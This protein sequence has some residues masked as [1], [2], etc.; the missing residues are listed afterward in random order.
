MNQKPEQCITGVLRTCNIK[1][2]FLSTL[3]SVCWNISKSPVDYFVYLVA[4]DLVA[5]L[6]FK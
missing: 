4:L 5:L 3:E 2:A 6:S 1:N